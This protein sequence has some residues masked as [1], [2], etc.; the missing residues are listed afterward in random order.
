MFGVF[1]PS[2]TVNPYK[3]TNAEVVA[4]LSIS[5]SIVSQAVRTPSRYV[6][7]AVGIAVPFSDFLTTYQS[8]LA[9]NLPAVIFSFSFNS[10]F[11]PKVFTSTPSIVSVL[12]SSSL[13]VPSPL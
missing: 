4:Q 8:Y 11:T 5:V 3:V 13:A 6:L 10:D 12:S 2:F 1:T 9:N 7:I